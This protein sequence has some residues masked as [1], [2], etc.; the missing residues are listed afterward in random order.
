MQVRTFDGGISK[1]VDPSLILSNEAVELLNVD[2]S[3]LTL[4]SSKNYTETGTLVSGYFYLFRGTYLSSSTERS[5]VEYQNKLYYTEAGKEARKF[6]GNRDSKLGIEPPSS[7]VEITQSDAIDG[8]HV[9]A[10]A[11]VLQYTYTY[12]NSS[13]DIESAPAPLSDE[14]SVDAD[15]RITL[16]GIEVTAD[17]QVDIIRI[18]RIGGDITVTTLV[19]EIPNNTASYIDTKSDLELEGRLLESQA[20]F[21][22]PDGAQFLVEAYGILFCAVDERLHFSDI[23]QPDVWPP[24]NFIDFSLDITMILPVQGGLLVCSRHRSHLL[25]GTTSDT[26]RKLDLTSEHGSISHL[27]AQILKTRPVWLAETGICTFDGSYITLLS[28][29]KLGLC[30]LDIVNS[31]VHNEVYYLCLTNGNLFAVDN[32]FGSYT[33]AEYQ[34]DKRLDNILSID[35][36]RYGRI[37]DK[38]VTLFDGDDLEF[39]YL[40]PKFTE[41]FH[42]VIKTYNNVYIRCDGDFTIKMFIDDEL[43]LTKS[44]TGNTIFDI[45]PPAGKQRGSAVQ[46]EITGTGTI[47]EYEFKVNGRQNG[48]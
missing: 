5:Y 23:G 26:F 38:L 28:Q 43:V 11:T 47:F 29:D 48:R 31:M 41:S 39:T 22:A 35:G 33:F 40:S 19:E 45:Q 44:I 21:P 15:Q 37:N 30:P 18:Y 32:R 13:D 10:D 36:S 7:S 14:F 16:S 12:Y 6:D 24:L 8:A 9:S 20:H 42:S 27:S 1:R 25:T 34:Y 3:E 2:N 4:K 17:I 46:F